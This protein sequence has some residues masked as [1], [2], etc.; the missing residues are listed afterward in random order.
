MESP[1]SRTLHWCAKALRLGSKSLGNVGE[2]RLLGIAHFYAANAEKATFGRG[3]SHVLADSL[4]PGF[5]GGSILRRLGVENCRHFL[6]VCQRPLNRV[7]G[8][9]SAG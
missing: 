8:L 5:E 1:A 2:S 7:G 9:S 3:L 6:Q 4:Q